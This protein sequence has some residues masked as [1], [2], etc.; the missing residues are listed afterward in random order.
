MGGISRG[1]VTAAQLENQREFDRLYET[2]YDAITGLPRTR[3]RE[4]MEPW[5]GPHQSTCSLYS[6]AG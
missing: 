3:C 6:S 4:C 5:P 1:E 2:G